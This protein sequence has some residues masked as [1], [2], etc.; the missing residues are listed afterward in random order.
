MDLIKTIELPQAIADLVLEKIKQDEAKE[1]VTQDKIIQVQENYLK[2]ETEKMKNLIDMRANGELTQAEYLEAKKECNKQVISLEEKIKELKNNQ[3]STTRKII[4][5]FSFVANLQDKFKNGISEEKR[6]IMQNLGSNLFLF[7]RKAD[8]Y[9]DLRLKPFQDEAKEVKEN[10]AKFEPLQMP[11]NTK[12]NRAFGP[13]CS[14]RCSL[15]DSNLQP[16]GPKP[17]TLS[18]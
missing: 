11:I 5:S 13:A 18:S 10:Y 3:N 1:S 12:Q 15:Q 7:N 9:L 16:L 17:S 2:K 6:D 8:F 4:S 14:T